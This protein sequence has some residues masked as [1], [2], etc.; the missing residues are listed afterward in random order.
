MGPRDVGPI[1]RDGRDGPYSL[2][3]FQGGDQTRS[4]KNTPPNISMIWKMK[5]M[6]VLPVEKAEVAAGA[7]VRIMSKRDEII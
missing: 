3:A 1:P 7:S 5:D 6:S 4:R 2:P